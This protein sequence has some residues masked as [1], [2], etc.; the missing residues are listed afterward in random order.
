MN[1]KAHLCTAPEDEGTA[2]DEAL[3]NRAIVKDAR[4]LV[5]TPNYTNEFASEA[6]VSHLEAI[7]NW[8]NWDINFNNVIVGRTFVQFARTQMSAMAL[9]PEDEKQPVGHPLYKPKYTHILW[10]DDDACIEPSILPKFILHNKDIVIAPYP[11]RRPGYEIGVLSSTAYRCQQCNW[12]GFILYSYDAGKVVVLD[13]LEKHTD[14]QLY[15]M[16][17]S[18]SGIGPKIARQISDSMSSAAFRELVFAEDWK[19][20]MQISRIGLDLAHRLVKELKDCVG[21]IEDQDEE[22]KGPN[23]C[24]PRAEE[25]VCPK[26]ESTDLWRDFHNHAS[27][28]NLSVLYNLDRGLIEVDGGGTHCMLAKTEAFYDRRGEVGGINAMPPA[29]QALIDKFNDEFTEEDHANYD[30]YLGDLPDETTTFYEENAAGKP[31]FLMPKRGTEDMYWCYRAKRKGVK[32]Y[33]DTDTFAPHIGFAP[34]I[35]KAVRREFEAQKLHLDS[36]K[37][38]K[39]EGGIV[40][41]QEL[42]KNGEDHSMPIRKPVVHADKIGNLV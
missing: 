7:V 13:K 26:C 27:Y 21:L 40:K 34:V 28:R 38:A 25:E 39:K 11:M 29:V 42:Q 1:N 18:V 6:H 36:S 35:T 12:Y 24:P 10:I 14:K 32:V 23:G 19:A 16:L 37:F 20:L 3:A 31:Y 2:T 4:V 17:I 33:C 30:H 15:D 22:E 9:T 8:T 5:A 41:L